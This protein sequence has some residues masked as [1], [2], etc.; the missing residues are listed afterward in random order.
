MGGGEAVGLYEWWNTYGME[1]KAPYNTP[2]AFD[3]SGIAADSGVQYLP[4]QQLI[5]RGGIILNAGAGHINQ[6]DID[7]ALAD[8]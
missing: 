2:V 1:E 4:T 7:D 3:T 5:G 8:R 6:S